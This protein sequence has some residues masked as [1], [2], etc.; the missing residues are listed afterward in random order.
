MFLAYHPISAQTFT[1]PTSKLH[2]DLW[3]SIPT[4]KL[5]VDFLGSLAYLTYVVR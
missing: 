4:S 5:H 2:V 1:I 3:F